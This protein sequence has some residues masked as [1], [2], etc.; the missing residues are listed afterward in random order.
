MSGR[1]TSARQTKGSTARGFREDSAPWSFFLP[2][3]AP[4]LD[5]WCFSAYNL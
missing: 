4:D 2:L 5:F 1:L 3:M